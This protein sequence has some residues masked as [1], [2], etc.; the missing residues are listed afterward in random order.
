MEAE[1][2]P[3]IGPGDAVEEEMV[4]DGS[5][6][7]E[8]AEV[9]VVRGEEEALELPFPE[10][11]LEAY[12]E[13]YPAKTYLEGAYPEAFPMDEGE[14]AVV[15]NAVKRWRQTWIVFGVGA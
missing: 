10:A 1:A 9:E 2:V 3:E 12:P 15:R 4:R 11:Y 13:A 14:E 8:K 7:E 6:Y 5:R